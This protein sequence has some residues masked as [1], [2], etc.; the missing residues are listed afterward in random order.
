MFCVWPKSAI[1]RA[2][3]LGGMHEK[4]SVDLDGIVLGGANRLGG[5]GTAVDPG[6]SAESRVAG[7]WF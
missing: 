2:G 1:L 5:L 4:V 3:F 6:E 7:L